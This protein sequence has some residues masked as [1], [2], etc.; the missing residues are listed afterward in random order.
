LAKE[1]NTEYGDQKGILYAAHS[2]PPF[3]NHAPK[4]QQPDGTPPVTKLIEA[5]GG[6]CTK[7]F[8]RLGALDEALNA[9]RAQAEAARKE[10]EV[11]HQPATGGASDPNAASATAETMKP[12]GATETPREVPEAKKPIAPAAPSMT[13]A[14]AEQIIEDTGKLWNQANERERAIG[15]RAAK[16]EREDADGIIQELNPDY[17]HPN[18]GLIRHY[19]YLESETRYKKRVDKHKQAVSEERAKQISRRDKADEAIAKLCEPASAYEIRQHALEIAAKEN[20]EASAVI[21]RH[22]EQQ[23]KYESWYE[24]YRA[25]KT[26][27]LE[28]ERKAA[29]P[30]IDKPRKQ[31]ERSRGMER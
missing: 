14:E 20:P 24:A 30:I 9:E 13:L 25:E 29:E 10:R 26:A 19:F 7:A 22:E 18:G 17:F 5:E 11:Q 1:L 3:E 31:P 15:L 6:L 21:K 4:Y 28:R 23:P 16:E 8:E 12:I 2:L 27:A